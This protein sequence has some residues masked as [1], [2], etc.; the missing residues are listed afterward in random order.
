MMEVLLDLS[1]DEEDQKRPSPKHIEQ[2]PER[3]EPILQPRKDRFSACD[4]ASDDGRKDE[5]EERLE[6]RLEMSH[7]SAERTISSMT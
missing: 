7:N 3:G 4:F 1:S 5:T 2:Q 6:E